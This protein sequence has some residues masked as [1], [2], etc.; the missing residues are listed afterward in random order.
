MKKYVITGSI[1]NISKPIVIG[2]LKA[3]KD[4]RVITR[5]KDS[6]KEIESLGAKA[7]M[8]SVDDL[9]FLQEAFKDADVVYTMIPP[10]WQTTNWR[11]SQNQVGKNYGQALQASGVK[12][13]VNLSS[14]GAHLGNGA[15]PVDGLYDFEQLLNKIPGLQVKHLRP[16]Y[17]FSNFL[18][19]IG[20]I[21]QG[22][23]MGGNFGEGEKVFL[24]HT[25]DI[26]AAALEELL[27]LTFSGNSARYILGDECSGQEIATAL[28]KAIGKDLSWVVFTDEQQKQGLLE[29]G[30]SETHAQGYTELGRSIREGYL[31]AD[32]RKNMPALT[33]TKLEDFAQEFAAAF[34]A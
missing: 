6:V 9:S 34:N 29:A 10:I 16:S 7:L 33:K 27:D 20:M 21:K 32:A 30:L 18:S 2:L 13:V 1:G 3:E 8:G 14:I 26:A 25:K 5:S 22:G 28:G 24:V 15:G 4:V 31:Q 11:A 23:I 12:F 19:Q 17:F